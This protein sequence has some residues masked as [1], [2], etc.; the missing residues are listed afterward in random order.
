MAQ[1]D[2]GGSETLQASEPGKTP[3]KR[4]RV[5]VS[6]RNPGGNAGFTD[7]LKGTQLKLTIPISMGVEHRR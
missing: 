4:V 5:W 6:L 7:A 1:L 3:A 2:S